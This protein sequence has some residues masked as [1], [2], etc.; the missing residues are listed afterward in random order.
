M[1]ILLI[2]S[3]SG[4]FSLVALGC[5][6]PVPEGMLAVPAGEFVMGNDQ[7]DS[8]N[9]AA[10]HGIVKPWFVD[11]GPAH[12]VYLPLY[13]IDQYEVTNIEYADFIKTEKHPPP[14]YWENGSYA[15]GDDHYPVVMVRWEEAQNYCRSK[16]GRLPNE[17]EWEKAARGGDQRTYPWGATFDAR[18]AN[19]GG[20]TG[21]LKPVGSFPEGKS[22]FGSFDMIGNVWEWTSDW[23]RP[24]PGSSYK[25][26][27]Y[28]KPLKV[29]R[30]N[31]W[32]P[33]GH[34]EPEVQNE[35]MKYHSTTTF[36]LFAPPDSTITDVGFRCM[37]PS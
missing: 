5:F 23:Y 14:P 28:G 7:I 37:R 34:Y 30:G 35:I 27:R 16:G 36:R 33:I 29:I 4:V 26:D 17:A 3:F 32:S 19:L 1:R 10:E 18:K 20:L 24:Y 22:P 12:K 2:I 6:R 15:K 13:Y 31:S 25:S 9:I 11:E 8:K 21:D